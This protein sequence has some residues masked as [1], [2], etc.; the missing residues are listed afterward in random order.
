[1]AK[2]FQLVNQA[3]KAL[4][5]IPSAIPVH[6]AGSVMS[7]LIETHHEY[8]KLAAQEKT[9]REAINAWKDVRLADLKN[10]KEILRQYLEE[11]FKE[12]KQMIDGLFEALDKGIENNNPELINVAIGGIVNIAS[13]S[14]LQQVD[15]LMFAMRNDDVKVIEF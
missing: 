2:G 5:A 12:R 1:M 6:A 13:Q 9:R 15:K 8:K 7:R 4:T 3:G 11:T 14:P 10:Q